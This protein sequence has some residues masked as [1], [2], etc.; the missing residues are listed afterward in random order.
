FEGIIQS[1]ML[2][3]DSLPIDISAMILPIHMPQSSLLSLWK[4]KTLRQ[5]FWTLN[6]MEYAIDLIGIDIFRLDRD[7]REFVLK[8][9]DT[10]PDAREDLFCQFSNGLFQSNT[11]DSDLFSSRS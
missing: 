7:P 3:C 9:F 10:V 11:P 8:L 5:G 6:N 2:D 4:T 1:N